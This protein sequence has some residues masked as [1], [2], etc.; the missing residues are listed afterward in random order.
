M[1]SVLTAATREA[2]VADLRALI[3]D[4]ATTNPTQL[5]HHSHGESWHDH[6]APDVVVFP[7]STDE[8]S[9]VIGLK[10]VIKVTPSDAR[11]LIAAW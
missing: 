2:L 10:A 9:A 8:V 5:E 6:A 7:G 3:G 11:Y 4:R 1:A